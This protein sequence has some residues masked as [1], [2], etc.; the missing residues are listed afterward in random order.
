MKTTGSS[1]SIGGA[2]GAS[3]DDFLTKLFPQKFGS[4]DS[5]QSKAP[6]SKPKSSF[7][8]NDPDSDSDVEIPAK[9]TGKRDSDESDFEFF[10]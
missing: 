8:F 6:P 4:G 3:G 10:G 7:F 5:P 2:V 9:K 1:A